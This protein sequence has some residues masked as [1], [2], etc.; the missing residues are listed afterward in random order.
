MI[1]ETFLNNKTWLAIISPTLVP[2]A[3]TWGR[4]CYEIK[5]SESLYIKLTGAEARIS[6]DD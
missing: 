5:K 2:S 3:V 1:K 6:R 4:M